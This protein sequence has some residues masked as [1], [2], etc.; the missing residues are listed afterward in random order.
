MQQ[1]R[2]ERL[3]ATGH[4]GVALVA[5][6]FGEPD[7]PAV[8][9]LH[10]GGQTRHSWGGTAT[11]LA[12]EGFYAVSA[13]SRGH[14]ESE[15]DPFGDYGL[16]ALQADTEA[17]CDQLHHPAI[18]GASMGGLTGLWTEGTRAEAGR[19]PACRALVLV[20]IAHRS[21]ELGIQRILDFMT[22]TPEGFASVQE[23][24]DA[25]AVFLPHRPRPQNLEGLGKNLRHS[26][27]GRYHWHW[28]PAFMRAGARPRPNTHAHVFEEHC[29]RLSIPVLLVRGRMS[30]VVSEEVVQEFLQLVPWAKYVD[31][32]DAHHMVAGDRNDAFTAPVVEF[33][34]GL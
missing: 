8:L 30:D 10:G 3:H 23:A 28:D 22:G 25:V 15:W 33:L 14:G 20:D 24:A 16:D 29:R 18:V 21:E 2:H 9:L 12:K 7:A 34:R 5:D 6:A 26:P 17:W 32:G 27:D 31:V 4:N 11:V 13:D 1:V 19:P